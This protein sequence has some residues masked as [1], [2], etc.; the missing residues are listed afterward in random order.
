MWEHAVQRN[1]HTTTV[2]TPQRQGCILC[3]EF[4]SNWSVHPMWCVFFCFFTNVCTSVRLIVNLWKQAQHCTMPKPLSRSL[5][6]W[7]LG[8]IENFSL[9][10]CYTS[11][12]RYSFMC[13]GLWNLEK[14]LIC[15]SLCR[16]QRIEGKQFPWK[17]THFRSL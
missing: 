16:Q 8:S 10:C 11:A 14:Q 17:H 3:S 1:A 5:Y 4:I 6:S 7:A 9:G 13:L 2:K 12:R 15:P